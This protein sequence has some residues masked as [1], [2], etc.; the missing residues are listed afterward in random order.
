[1]G[2]LSYVIITEK[3][4]SI[5]HPKEFYRNER[6]YFFRIHISALENNKTRSNFIWNLRQIEKLSFRQ[7]QVKNINLKIFSN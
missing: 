4:I 5:S 3:E 7:V 2:I 6:T 1:M